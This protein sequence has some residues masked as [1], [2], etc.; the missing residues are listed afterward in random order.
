MEDHLIA[1]DHYQF[2]LLPSTVSP[3]LV[4]YCIRFISSPYLEDALA[5]VGYSFFDS[6]EIVSVL[7]HYQLPKYQ[8]KYLFFASSR[9][10]PVISLN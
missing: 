9:K 2:G 3:Q 6:Y 4:H 1:L 5:T 10:E 8:R 7:A